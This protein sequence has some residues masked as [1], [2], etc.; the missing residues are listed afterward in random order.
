VT[1]PSATPRTRI[2]IADDHASIR[3][4]LRYLLDAEPDLEII[5]VAKDAIGALGMATRLHPDVLVIYYE[6][7]GHQGLFV[8]CAVRSATHSPRVILYTMTNEVIT[9]AE[10]AGVDACVSKAAAPGV[11]LDA[12]RGSRVPAPR[13]RPRALLVEDDAAIRSDIRRAL[14]GDGFD[15][16]ETGD[17]FQTL[18]ECERQLPRV[19]IL[20]A[21]LLRM[22]GR[23]FATAYHRL[24]S[25]RAPII[26]LSAF[27]EDRQIARELGAAAWL[28]KPLS[29]EQLSEAVHR[30][31]PAERSAVA[32]G[33]VS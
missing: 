27:D 29:L 33:S 28:S 23:E 14:E 31:A 25:A 19:V 12:I 20:D 16:I 26:V 11:L 5:G 2:V 9:Y 13:T 22:S 1:W 15:I 6:L 17:G 30:V 10:R 4:N 24:R 7:S 32:V 21:A 8:A 3:E 18:A